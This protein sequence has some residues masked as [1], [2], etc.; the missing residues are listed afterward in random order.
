MFV[1]GHRGMVGSALVRRLQALGHRDILTRTRAELDLLDARAVG[2][3]LAEQ[4]P[5][6]V[7]I[8]AARVGG[9][10]ANNTLRA[11]FLYENLQIALNLI[12]SAHR[13]GVQRLMYFASNCIY[14]RE[15]P[16]PMHEDRL[17]TGP[18]EPTNEPYAIAKIAGL[19]LCESYNRQHAR[20]Y[21]AVMPASLYGPNDNY[22]PGSSHVL[23]A[24]LR[25]AH[26]ARLRGDAELTVWGSGTPRRE[27]LYIDDLAEACVMLAESGY[28]GPPINIGCGTDLSIRELAETVVDVTGFR[29][30]LIFDARQ[31]DGIARKLLDS[32]RIG[33]LGWRPTV[34]LAEGIRRAYAVAPFVDR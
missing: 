3:F 22:E 1:A 25:R 4:R 32:S 29:G 26:E 15:C 11:D 18:L 6:Y 5:D 31:P 33:A 7:F 2:A 16:Q 34:A 27:F 14:P 23:P 10:Q 28:D 12:D 17:L 9:I 24:L 8:A 20:Q 13:A 30:R 19:K 21:I